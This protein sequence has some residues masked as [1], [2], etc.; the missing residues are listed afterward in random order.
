MTGGWPQVIAIFVGLFAL[1][2]RREV[3]NLKCRN[4]RAALPN[5]TKMSETVIM[6]NQRPFVRHKEGVFLFTKYLIILF[7]ATDWPH[8]SFREMKSLHLFRVTR[9]S[10]HTRHTQNMAKMK[11]NTY[12]TSNDKSYSDRRQNAVTPLLQ[13]E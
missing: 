9:L 1:A 8:D 5:V 2:R 11:G 7:P 10:Y 6:I 13:L 12:H 4:F 3:A